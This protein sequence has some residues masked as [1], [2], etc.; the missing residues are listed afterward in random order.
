MTAQ[1]VIKKFF[2][3]LANHGYANSD[4][5]GVNM[6]DSAVRASSRYSDIQ[7]VIDAMKSDQTAAEMEAVEEVLGS[8]YAGKT[9][10]E[11]DSTILSADAKTYDTDNKSNAY[12]DSSND[13]RSTVENFIKERMAY[14]FLEKYCGIILNQKFFFN[15][16]GTA[17]T[18][19]V[20]TGNVDTG[21]ITGSDAGTSSV[22]TA[23][24]VVPEI[25][26]NTYTA[27]TSTP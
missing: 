19:G 25:F 2:N 24:S 7:E 26:I 11:I 13:S 6:L 16:S 14:I 20:S 27:A 10:S 18:W 17:D 22:K 4:S 1:E 23:S 15:K 3:Q 21:A 8:D 12:K 5:I 9:L